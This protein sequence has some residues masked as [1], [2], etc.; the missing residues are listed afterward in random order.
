MAERF[1][2]S[3]DDPYTWVVEGGVGLS[4]RIGI[5]VEYSRVSRVA[6]VT[7]GSSFQ[8]RGEQHERTLMP[9]VRVRVTASRV[10]A[11]DAVGGVGVLFQEHERVEFPCF[12]GNCPGRTE[13]LTRRVPAVM[14]GADVPVRLAPHLTVAATVRAHLLRRG[15]AAFDP[16]TGRFPPWQYEWSSSTRLAFGGSARLAW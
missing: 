14:F 7:R 6:A 1:N 4:R 12:S 15:E 13:T 11:L 2:L 10:V 9:L 8:S 16:V 5:G 3:A